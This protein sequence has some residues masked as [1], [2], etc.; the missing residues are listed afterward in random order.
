MRNSLR[1]KKNRHKNFSIFRVQPSFEMSVTEPNQECTSGGNSAPQIG[2]FEA[3]KSPSHI[4]QLSSALWGP[5]ETSG[6]IAPSSIDKN[7]R[8]VASLRKI[9]EKTK[10]KNYKCLWYFEQDF[11]KYVFQKWSIMHNFWCG[12]WCVIILG[13]EIGKPG[14]Y[15]HFFTCN[16]RVKGW[17]ESY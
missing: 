14:L 15:A 8:P 2:Y 12:K 1:Y 3:L 9:Q 16:S 7:G 10:S 13:K 11:L 17:H 5:L 4:S 6:L